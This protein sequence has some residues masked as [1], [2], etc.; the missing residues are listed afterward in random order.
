M[1]LILPL[2]FSFLALSAASQSIDLAT[3]KSIIRETLCQYLN[4]NPNSAASYLRTNK[5]YQ[6][7]RDYHNMALAFEPDSAKR[8]DI[9]KDIADFDH[10]VDSVTLQLQTQKVMVQLTDTIYAYQYVAGSKD[11]KTEA[12]WQNNYPNLVDDFQKN[13]L[14]RFDTVIGEAYIEL[15]KQQIHYKEKSIPIE[16]SSFNIDHYQYQKKATDCDKNEFCLQADKVYRAVF[17]ADGTK[18]CY[19]FSFLCG[20]DKICRSFIFIKKENGKWVYV[21]DY[22]TWIIDEA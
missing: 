13:A 4:T 18:G 20:D 16:L 6:M 8:K 21:D 15:V 11:L 5:G 12:G 9:Y 10:Y 1:K 3:E 14:H 22:P 17:N 19:L 2:L 7:M